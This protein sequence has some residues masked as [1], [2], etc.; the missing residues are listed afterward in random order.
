[1]EARTKGSII[2][3]T[4]RS[5]SPTPRLEQNPL[6][7]LANMDDAEALW[8]RPLTALSRFLREPCV[9]EIE[10]RKARLTLAAITGGITPLHCMICM[11]QCKQ[12]GSRN[13]TPQSSSSSPS[14]IVQSGDGGAE[15]RRASSP[16]M[17][18]RSIGHQQARRVTRPQGSYN[19]WGPLG[20]L[21]RSS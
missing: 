15:K 4:A 18:R 16:P 21:V 14:I 3:S 7:V 5:L 2:Y 20:F 6:Q 11:E 19:D 12:A 17:I 9:P 13:H 8:W 10:L 1:M